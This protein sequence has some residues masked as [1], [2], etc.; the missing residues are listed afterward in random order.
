MN[1]KTFIRLAGGGV[2]A[3]ASG[4][5]AAVSGAAVPDAATTAWR[6]F[7]SQDDPRKWALAYALLAPNPHNLQ[8]WMADL[9]TPGEIL[10]TLDPERRLPATDPFGRQIMMDAGAFLEL[11]AI[12]AAKVGYQADIQLFPEGEPEPE[13]HS[14]PVARIRLAKVGAIASSSLFAAIPNRRTERGVYDPDHPV[15]ET[16]VAAMED[17]VRGMNVRFGVA[18]RVQSDTSDKSDKARLAE[19]RRIARDGWRVEVTT[20]STFMESMRLMRIGGAEIDRHRDGIAAPSAAFLAADKLGLFNRSRYPGADSM[21]IKSQLQRFDDLTASTPSYLWLTTSTN[22][23]AAQ[24]EAGRAYARLNLAGTLLGLA[25]H[26]N[27]QALQEFPEMAS[28]YR[29]IHQLLAPDQR[30]ATVQM[31]ARLGTLPQGVATSKPAPRRGLDAQ[32][33]KG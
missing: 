12:A 9:R 23:R 16:Q 33:Q 5:L 3:A 15:S 6:D 10:L 30:G 18:G 32:L 29:D 21:A 2:L 7:P 26:P 20:E 22:T 14:K 25:M 19:I 27:E 17:S 28:N 24:I 13:P 31:L 11:L 1:R 4:W 8:P